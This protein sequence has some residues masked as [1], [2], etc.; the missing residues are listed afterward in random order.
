MNEAETTATQPICAGCISAIDQGIAEALAGAALADMQRQVETLQA[1]YDELLGLFA[2][3]SKSRD[4]E[5]KRGRPFLRAL[6]PLGAIGALMTW[7]R[8]L[9]PVAAVAL[10]ASSAGVAINLPKVSPAP[11]APAVHKVRRRLGMPIT[12]ISRSPLLAY[13]VAE[14]SKRP[15]AHRPRPTPTPTA[16]ITQPS[17]DP[18]PSPA[19][20]PSVSPTPNPSASLDP[21][22]TSQPSPG[23]SPQVPGPPMASLSAGGG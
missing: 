20:S 11:V 18:S 22:S 5:R 9:T 23:E 13:P 3:I 21:V 7:R 14:K 2:D 4:P 6:P 19:P 12:S 15:K 17:E 8:L 16:T 1:K 10:A